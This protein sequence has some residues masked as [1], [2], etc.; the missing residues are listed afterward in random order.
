MLQLQAVNNFDHSRKK[1]DEMFLARQDLKKGF[2]NKI[3]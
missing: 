3:Y 1:S 2:K